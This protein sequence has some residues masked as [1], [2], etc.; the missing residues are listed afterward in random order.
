MPSPNIRVSY[1][2]R[3]ASN[4][5]SYGE[6]LFTNPNNIST[7]LIW[8]K[9]VA[10]VESVTFIP[11]MPYFRPEW[12]GLPTLFLFDRSEFARNCDDHDWHE[13]SS[14]DGVDTTVSMSSDMTIDEFIQK[15]ELTH[16]KRR[17]STTS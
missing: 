11:D 14:V 15:V 10:A 8:D 5:K 6:A 12:V 16:L 2:Y 9:L 17:E 7:E 13:L 1:L 4:Y 3:D